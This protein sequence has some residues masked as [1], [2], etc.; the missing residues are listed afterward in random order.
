MN[1]GQ[2]LNALL[3]RRKWLKMDIET[4]EANGDDWADGRASLAR[5]ELQWIDSLIGR[6]GVEP[7]G[8]PS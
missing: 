1:E 4:C 2:I 5:E 8:R 3:R 7:K 6:M